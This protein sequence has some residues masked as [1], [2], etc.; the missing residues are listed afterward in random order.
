VTLYA[1]ILKSR[2]HDL[3]NHLIGDQL[4]E[5]E[6]QKRRQK[7]RQLPAFNKNYKNTGIRIRI[8]AE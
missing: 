4:N 5:K 3:F 2:F 7:S 6:I 1:H 8:K